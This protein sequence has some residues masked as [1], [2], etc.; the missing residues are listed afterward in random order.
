MDFFL[1]SL[2]L[3]QIAFSRCGQWI[4]NTTKKEGDVDHFCDSPTDGTE[5]KLQ[6]AVLSVRDILHNR[7]TT[8]CFHLTMNLLWKK[9]KKDRCMIMLEA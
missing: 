8:V 7:D 4:K 2:T 3:Y 9:K 1:L 6:P 5:H